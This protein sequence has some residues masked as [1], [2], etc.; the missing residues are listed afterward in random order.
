MD[1]EVPLVVSQVNPEDAALARGHHRQPQLLDDAAGAGAH[2][3]PGL[4]RARAS[5]S[6]TPTRPSRAPAPRRSPSW[7]PRSALTPKATPKLA[8]VYPHPIALQRP[9]RDR[10]LPRERLLAGGMEGRHR[11]SQDPPSAGPADLAARPS[12]SRSSWATGG[13]PRRDARARCR[14][15]EPASC[16]P[17]LPGVV[18]QDDPERHVYPLATDAAG[19]DEVFVGRVRRD[20]SVR[21]WPGVLGCQRQ[22]PQGRGDQRGGDRRAPRQPRLGAACQGAPACRSARPPSGAPCDSRRATSRAR[23]DRSRGPDLYPLPAAPGTHAG[24]AR[25]GRS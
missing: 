15:S 5:R 12:A 22:R 14:R 2:G 1:P 7:R 21:A 3:A 23:G 10:R 11:E 20:P 19:R 18:V 6:W 13:R 4:G 8:N 24:R 16:S 25:G 9:A 17:P